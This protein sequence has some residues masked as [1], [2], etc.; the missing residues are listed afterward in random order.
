MRF[1]GVR[2]VP[3]VEPEGKHLPQPSIYSL[4][5]A[6]DGSLWIGTGHGIAHWANGELTNYP[7]VVGRVNSIQEDGSGTIWMVRTRLTGQIGVLCGVEGSQIRCYGPADGLGCSNGANDLAIDKHGNHWIG[8]SEA[9]CRWKPD[10]SSTYLQKELKTTTGLIGVSAV[11]A[12]DD[13]VVWVGIP[14][15]GKTFGLQQ[16]VDGVSTSYAV[17]GMDGASLAVSALFLDRDNAL[18]VGTVNQ[19]IYRVYK[20][21]ADHFGSSDGLSSDSVQYFYQD[22]EGDVWGVT[23]KGVDRF[24]QLRAITFSLR[25]GLTADGVGSVSAARDGALWIGNQGALDVLRQDTISK[26]T[27]RDGLPGR[28]ITSLLEDS[29]GRLWVGVDG[30]L[31]VYDHKRFRLIKRPDGS[32]VGVVVGITEDTDHNIWVSHTGVVGNPPGLLRIRDFKVVES[33]SFASGEGAVT[34]VSDNERGI[35]LSLRKGGLERYRGGRFESFALSHD[36]PQDVILNLLV[37]PDGSVWGATDDGLI[38][39]KGHRAA[40]LNSKNGLPCDSIYSLIRDNLGSLWLSTRCGFVMIPESEVAKWQKQPDSSLKIRSFDIFDGAQPAR[41]SFQPSVSRS[42]DGRLWFANDV[43][44]QMIDPSHI[45]TNS[46]PPPVH[47]EQIVADK[48]HYAPTNKVSLPAL[49]RDLEIDY[50]ALSFVVPQKVRFRYKLE[51]RDTDWQDPMT[52]RQAFYSDLRPGSY[53][54]HVIACNNDGVWNEEGATLNFS[55]ERWLGL[56]EQIPV[57]LR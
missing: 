32:P 31:A 13:G 48:K 9:L 42:V 50:T 29:K 30:E 52:R 40:T 46:L 28:D 26:I 23:S 27:A 24:R 39:W 53:R 55:I 11:A 43:F 4:L 35:W 5:G 25:E 56:F 19:G 44:V 18:W 54:F 8:A 36:G 3:W 7:S 41:T 12:G 14:R 49:T 45:E 2:F 37:D 20:G 47:I 17:P 1:D 34:I 6:K 38:W 16:L 57:I 22:R 21:R 10:S 33:I 15:P 51:G